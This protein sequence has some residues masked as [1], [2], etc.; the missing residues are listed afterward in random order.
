MN[1]VV[2]AVASFSVLAAGLVWINRPPK[3]QSPDAPQDQFSALPFDNIATGYKIAPVPLNLDGR[4][5]FLVG[6]GSYLVNAVGGCNDCHTEPSYI[7]GGDPYRGQP[8]Q[9]NTAAY[10]GGGRMFGPF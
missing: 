5:V 8:K 3:A 7:P 6:W 10:L 9:I 4:D 1:R 2:L